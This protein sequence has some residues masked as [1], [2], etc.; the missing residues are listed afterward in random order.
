[1]SGRPINE[2]RQ[3]AIALGLR[4]YT[5][6]AHPKCG[7]TERYVS[8]GGCVH[9]ARVKAAEQRDELKVLKAAQTASLDEKI[10]TEIANREEFA[11]PLPLDNGKTPEQIAFEQ[12]IE[13]ML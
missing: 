7:T 3:N 13:D 11:P 1:M 4:T 12:S 5:G 8:G 6:A 10:E 9:C 2:D